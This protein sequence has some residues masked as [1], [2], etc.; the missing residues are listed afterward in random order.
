MKIKIERIENEG[1][2]FD[3]DVELHWTIKWLKALLLEKT[4]EPIALQHL[5]FDGIKFRTIHI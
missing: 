4:G 2:V 5:F 3:L 1:E